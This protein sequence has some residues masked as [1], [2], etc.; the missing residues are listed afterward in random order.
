MTF[1]YATQVVILDEAGVLKKVVAAHDV[2]R[3]MNRT[4][5]EGQVEGSVHMGLG[6]ALTEDCPT[7]GG[8]PVS[9][10]FGDLQILRSRDT[11]E[12][13]V[14]LIEVP[15]PIG[16]CYGAKGV[17]EI[18][19]VPTAGAVAG[20]LQRF[21][22]IYRHTLPMRGSAAARAILPR[23]KAEEDHA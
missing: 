17:G 1:G 18:G 6:Y 11:P 3:V 4:T 22:G 23:K 10:K 15:D 21:D 16:A 8:F 9:T 2:G 14:K 20:A 12:I 13:E 7:E 5:C 19:L